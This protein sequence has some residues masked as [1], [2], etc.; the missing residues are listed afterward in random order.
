VSQPGPCRTS[1][2]STEPFYKTE[3]ILRVRRNCRNCRTGGIWLDILTAIGYNN[4]NMEVLFFSL[5]A[6]WGG[7]RLSGFFFA[8]CRRLVQWAGTVLPEGWQLLT[9]A[10][11][12]PASKPGDV[13]ADALNCLA[14]CQRQHRRG[15]NQYQQHFPK[16]LQAPYQYCSLYS[17]IV[18]IVLQGAIP[19]QKH[20]II[21]LQRE[22]QPWKTGMHRRRQTVRVISQTACFAYRATLL[23]P[24]TIVILV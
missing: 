21:R 18:L 19:L 2:A 15:K 24:S 16:H 12:A 20:R 6:A 7:Y 9:P 5:C 22:S 8:H 10:G 13:T 4:G 1:I 23:A 3:A 14:A 11:T 17:L